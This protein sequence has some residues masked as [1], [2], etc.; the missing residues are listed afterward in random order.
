MLKIIFLYLRRRMLF[1]DAGQ[2]TSNQSL[3]RRP[4]KVQYPDRA[5]HS[6][7]VV[8]FRTPREVSVT[9]VLLIYRSKKG[10]EF[11]NK[12]SYLCGGISFGLPEISNFPFLGPSRIVPV[13]PT[14]PPTMCTTLPPAKSMYPCKAKRAH[15]TDHSAA[16]LETYGTLI[17]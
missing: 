13:R 15:T 6:R 2:E 11:L 8:A 14:M 4:E 7:R 5:F 1:L 17:A 16:Y 3:I 10:C 9:E 12:A